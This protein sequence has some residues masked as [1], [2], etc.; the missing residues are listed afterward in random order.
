MPGRSCIPI[1][2]RHFTKLASFRPK[3]LQLLDTAFNQHQ[4]DCSVSG[5]R[6]NA[7]Q[8]RTQRC[9]GTDF[10][11]RNQP[12]TCLRLTSSRWD[13]SLCTVSAATRNW[14]STR[15]EERVAVLMVSD[16][17]FT[18]RHC[19]RQL[20]PAR[21]NMASSEPATTKNPPKTRFKARI[22]AGDFKAPS[23]RAARAE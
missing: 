2:S 21:L 1:P 13:S 20:Q 23:T 12:S 3:R 16:F 7:K 4:T 15:S 22:C 8:I 10:D 17:T 6:L 11:R 14:S 9:R 18:N 19:F 5:V